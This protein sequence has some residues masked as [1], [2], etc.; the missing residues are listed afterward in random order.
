MAFGRGRFFVS[1][2]INPKFMTD[3]DWEIYAGLLK[4]ARRNQEVLQNTVIL[5]SRV[6]LGEPYAYAHWSGSAGHRRGSESLQ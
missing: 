3:A 6:E 5:T 4:W 2:Y 1:T